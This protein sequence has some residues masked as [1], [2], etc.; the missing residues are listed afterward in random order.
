[1]TGVQTCALPIWRNAKGETLKL[2]FVDDNPSFERVTNP[3]VQNLRQIGIDAS[4]RQIDPAQM[5]ERQKNHEYD[6]TPGRLVMSMAPSVE[7][8]TIYGT[9]GAE[10]AGSYNFSGLAD[11]VVDG[12]IELIIAADSREQLDGRVKAL[13]RVLRAKQIWVPNWTK[14]SFWIAYWDVFGRPAQP[15]EYSRG[16][17]Y[18]WFDQAKYDKLKSEG[19][20]R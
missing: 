15:P 8:R 13:D 4:Y 5:E 1:M 20:L 7:L 6:I 14:G 2:E 17:A 12:I 19:A 10:A 18:W 11:P 9:Q 16:D 3:F